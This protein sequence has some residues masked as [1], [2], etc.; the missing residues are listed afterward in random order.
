MPSRY[1]ADVRVEKHPDYD[2][3]RLV[4]EELIGLRV[5]GDRHG[6]GRHA[7]RRREPRGRG[8]AGVS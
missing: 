4:D 5:A 7:G 3:E 2:G 8:A 1:F 6:L